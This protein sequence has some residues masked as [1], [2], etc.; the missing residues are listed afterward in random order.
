MIVLETFGQYVTSVQWVD[1]LAI[2]FCKLC[3]LYV[4]KMIF[5][6]TVMYNILKCIVRRVLT[7]I[8]INATN[9][10]QS[11]SWIFLSLS[12]V[13]LC[14]FLIFLLLRG[15]RYSLFY[16]HSLAYLTAAYKWSHTVYFLLCLTS[17]SLFFI[18]LFFFLLFFLKIMKRFTNL[19]VISAQGPC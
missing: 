19:N 2:S 12:K 14:S 7:S 9:T 4:F 5:K 18:F 10:P 6:N 8:L 3:Q 17:P 1:I 11:K 15:Q 13:P 16:P